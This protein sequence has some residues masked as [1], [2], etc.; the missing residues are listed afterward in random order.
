MRC[1]VE[2]RVWGAQWRSGCGVHSGGQGG[3]VVF[4]T[5]FQHQGPVDRGMYAWLER[6]TVMVVEVGRGAGP[7]RACKG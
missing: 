2:V 1:T 5:D 3:S 4:R 6:D 7:D